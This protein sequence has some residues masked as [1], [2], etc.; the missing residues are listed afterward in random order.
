MNMASNFDV[1]NNA[2]Q[3]QMTTICHWMKPP[4]KI[5][6]VCLWAAPNRL[7]K[8][9]RLILQLRTV[10]PSSTGLWL[11][12]HCTYEKEWWQHTFLSESK[13]NGE[14]SWSNSPD[15]GTNFWA[16]MQWLY[17]KA[18]K[19]LGIVQL[20]RCIFF[21]GAGN[22]NVNYLHRGPYWAVQIVLA[23][24]VF[25]TLVKS[26]ALKRKFHAWNHYCAGHA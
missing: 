23:G 24:R 19:A 3:I 21:Q 16:G 7:K 22:V 10:K 17:P 9:K 25:E 12:I 6:C 14:R 13:T 8:I 5:F 18:W 11:S 26:Y 4:M 2:H 1:T 15:M 20:F